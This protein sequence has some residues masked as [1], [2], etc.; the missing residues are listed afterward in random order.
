[1]HGDMGHGM[2]FHLHYITM[3]ICHPAAFLHPQAI[4]ALII[5][6]YLNVN[7][8]FFFGTQYVTNYGIQDPN[9]VLT[10]FP[11]HPPT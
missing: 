5:I 4:K 10:F 6:N 1:M 8:S 9:V 3:Q 2:R 11:F 7:W